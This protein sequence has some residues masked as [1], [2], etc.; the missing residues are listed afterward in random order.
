MKKIFLINMTMN[1]NATIL[2]LRNKAVIW[3][4]IACVVC[5]GAWF[6]IR[7]LHTESTEIQ[8]EIAK[9]QSENY[10]ILYEWI[11]TDTIEDTADRQD[12]QRWITIMALVPE[13]WEI[14]G[15]WTPSA[16]ENIKIIK[17][18]TQKINPNLPYS[19]W[20]RQS[21]TEEDS[22]V[23]TKIQTGI[24]EIIPVFT[25]NT[26]GIANDIIG[27]R[28]TMTTLVQ[29]IQKYLV[30]AFLLGNVLWNI[31]IDGV[32]FEENA[33]EIGIYEVPLR[34]EAV[35]NKKVYNLLDFL[36]KTWWIDISK[37][38]AGHITIT[39]KFPVDGVNSKQKHLSS[40]TNLLIIPESIVIEPA[41]DTWWDSSWWNGPKVINLTIEQLWN[42]DM[43]VKFFIRWAS[44][45][46][47][48]I[49]DQKISQLL[50]IKSAPG[51]ISQALKAKNECGSACP[52]KIALDDIVSLLQKTQTAYR[53]ILAQEGAK[54]Q[55]PL[56]TVRSRMEILTL[57]K[58]LESKL[59]ALVSPI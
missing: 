10:N 1:H 21:W 32:T 2:W 8:T 35:S 28:I 50:E 37:D 23:L 27:G 43:R 26:F 42:V 41:W 22:S 52:N 31:G 33:P 7:S 18:L 30:D 34:F 16:A 47:I 19:Q 24:A 29:Y 49:L 56:E 17:Q 51:L 14:A 39:N 55:S 57:L 46:H 53:S 3:I 25:G 11:Q 12:N 48:A 6:F 4:S 45:E 36:N 38:E 9:I 20:L 13:M 40:L 59:K 58:N 5:I 44:S 54:E 15:V